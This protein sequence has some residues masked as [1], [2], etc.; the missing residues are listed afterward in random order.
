MLLMLEAVVVVVPIPRES[1]A[2][3]AIERPTLPS[4]WGKPDKQAIT[5][6]TESTTESVVI[7]TTELLEDLLVLTT[8]SGEKIV[9]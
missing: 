6:T 7:A 9:N 3:L 4:D 1:A 2:T 5:S 8:Q